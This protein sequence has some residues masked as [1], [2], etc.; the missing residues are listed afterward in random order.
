MRFL[1]LIIV[2]FTIGCENDPLVNQN[3]NNNSFYPVCKTEKFSP[4]DL[5]NNTIYRQYCCDDKL[6]IVGVA[7]IPDNVTEDYRSETYFNDVNNCGGCGVTCS[8]DAPYCLCVLKGDDL[9][10]LP[11][12]CTG[13][14]PEEN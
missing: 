6:T 13:I 2:L 5:I 8:G 10:R 14:S 3:N 11:C 1:I 4:Y 9:E 12:F 7:P